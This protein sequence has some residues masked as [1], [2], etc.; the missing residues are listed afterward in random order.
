MQYNIL[1]NICHEGY[2]LS[3]GVFYARK[4]VAGFAPWIVIM[5]CCGPLDDETAMYPHFLHKPRGG[6]EIGPVE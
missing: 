6:F 3:F 1:A 4:Y 2:V 5:L